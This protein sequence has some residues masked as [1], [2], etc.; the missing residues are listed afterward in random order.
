MTEQFRMGDEG[1][2]EIETGPGRGSTEGNVP[3]G[4]VLQEYAETE[5]QAAI[6]LVSQGIQCGGSLSL[7]P[8]CNGS[9][10]KLRLRLF[11][12]KNRR[13]PSP[14]IRTP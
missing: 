10:L 14:R 11:I 2:A 4:E 5:A 7:I 13:P 8:A 3:W 12:I 6:L 1:S 9:K